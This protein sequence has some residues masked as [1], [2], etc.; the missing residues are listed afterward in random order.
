MAENQMQGVQTFDNQPMF[1]NHQTV[2]HQPD[3]IM[4]DF[5]SVLPQFGIDNQPTLVIS[6]RVIVLDPYTAKEFNKV[7][8]DNIKNYEKKFGAITMPDQLKKA[9]KE[10][11]K[12][13]KNA[14]TGEKPTYYG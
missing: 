12:L 6:H 5:K 8:A 9:Q 14:V 13:Q 11:K 2:N 4:I 1:S 3:K 10:Q 7:L